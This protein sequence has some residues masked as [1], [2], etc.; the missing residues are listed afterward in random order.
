MGQRGLDHRR[1]RR[2]HDDVEDHVR[3]EAREHRAEVGAGG[4]GAAVL[5]RA[6][7]GRGLV[8]VHEAHDRHR[9]AE[10]GSVPQGGEPALRHGTAS[11]HDCPQ[12]DGAPPR[13]PMKRR[14]RLQR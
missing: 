9:I 4:R 5:G 7:P 10:R 12:H 3:A 11:G 8:K 14:K 2:W 1:S 6:V 13:V